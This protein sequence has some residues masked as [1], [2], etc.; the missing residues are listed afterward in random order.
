MQFIGLLTL[1][2]I[3]KNPNE[4]QL[5]KHSVVANMSIAPKEDLCVLYYLPSFCVLIKKLFVKLSWIVV[6]SWEL[7]L[8]LWCYFKC[9]V[10]WKFV[11]CVICN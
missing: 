7:Y 11:V 5:P 10:P 4:K 1:G 8:V 3:Q 9:R 2:R 6:Q